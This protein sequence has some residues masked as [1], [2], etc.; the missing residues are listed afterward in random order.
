MSE[1]LDIEFIPCIDFEMI[2]KLLDCLLVFDDSCE[3]ICQEKDATTTSLSDESSP[4]EDI[5]LSHP[6]V[7][8]LLPEP[9]TQ[10]FRKA[11]PL[12]EPA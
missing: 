8:Q 2:N 12:A 3:E 1:K 7:Q 5:A 9:A 6:A 11:Y 10:L 4:V